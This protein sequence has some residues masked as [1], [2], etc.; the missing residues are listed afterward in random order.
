MKQANF[1]EFSKQQL[2]LY[3]VF[4]IHDIAFNFWAT[5]QANENL[6][7]FFVENI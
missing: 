3:V 2:K 7:D 4:M 5:Q 1:N 6:S